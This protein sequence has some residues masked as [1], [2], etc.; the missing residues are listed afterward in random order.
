MGLALFYLPPFKPLE[1]HLYQ[2]FPPV[3][4]HMEK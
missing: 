3:L 2:L 1:L 4:S